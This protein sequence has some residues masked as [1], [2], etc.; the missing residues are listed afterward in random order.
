MSNRF[1]GLSFML[2][3]LICFF[4][5]TIKYLGQCIWFL[6]AYFNLSWA[7][8]SYRRPRFQKKKFVFEV[9]ISNL[10]FFCADWWSANENSDKRFFWPPE[11]RK[12]EPPR[13]KNIQMV[14][15]RLFL[16]RLIFPFVRTFI[17]VYWCLRLN[18]IKIREILLL[19]LEFTVFWA[20]GAVMKSF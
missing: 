10:P 15:S 13:A 16:A 3:Q 7:Y 2:N 11:G 1:Y 5:T 14:I 8:T 9:S 4:W 18:K 12:V 6:I 17:R 19:R 20:S